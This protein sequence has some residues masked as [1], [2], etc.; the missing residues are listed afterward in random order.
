MVGGFAKSPGE[1]PGQ[2]RL[3]CSRVRFIDADCARADPFHTYASLASLALFG[4]PEDDADLGLSE[5][6]PLRNVGV[7]AVDWFLSERTR[8]GW[9]T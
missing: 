8:L 9:M 4:T 2:R 6:D 3:P 7:R 1:R 5:M